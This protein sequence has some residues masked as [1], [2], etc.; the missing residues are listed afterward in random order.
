MQIEVTGETER[1][2]QAALASGRFSNLEELLTV[3]TRPLATQKPIP[4]LADRLDIE[5]LAGDEGVGVFHADHKVPADLWPE[6]ESVDDF[7]DCVRELRRSGG[8]AR[9]RIR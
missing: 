6:N 2:I 5:K 7:V 1:L 4:P 8:S 9:S 3:L